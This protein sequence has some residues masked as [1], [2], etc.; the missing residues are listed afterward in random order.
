LAEGRC[1]ASPSLKHDDS[2][3]RPLLAAN[4]RM[5]GPAPCF[6]YLSDLRGEV[7]GF[8]QDMSHPKF[9]KAQWQRPILFASRHAFGGES[10]AAAQ[11]WGAGR[12]LGND[13]PLPV[14]RTSDGAGFSTSTIRGPSS[15]SITRQGGPPPLLQLSGGPLAPRLP[16][17]RK[18]VCVNPKSHRV[19]AAHPRLAFSCAR[20]QAR[21]FEE[22]AKSRPPPCPS[23]RPAYLP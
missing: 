6:E 3:C 12:F 2:E 14:C 23:I 13:L 10:S 22:T 1:Y 8:L 7:G 19:Q 20:I 5:R 11:N 18:K 9:T 21:V 4:R 17:L 15:P 16:V